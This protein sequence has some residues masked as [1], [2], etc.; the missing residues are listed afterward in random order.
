MSAS[1]RLRVLSRRTTDLR[2]HPET[3]EEA[4]RELLRVVP[5]LIAVVEAVERPYDVLDDRSFYRWQRDLS[6]AY[7]ALQDAI[8]EGET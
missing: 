2:F 5:A 1:D 3:A 4:R 8:D 6:A 7:T